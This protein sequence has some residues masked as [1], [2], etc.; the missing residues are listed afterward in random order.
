M[1]KLEIIIRSEKLDEMK[2]ILDEC[3]INGAIIS[4]IMGYGRQKGYKSAYKG[5]EYIINLLPKIK[6]EIIIKDNLVEKII[7][8]IEER[9][10]TDNIGDGKIFIYNVEDCVKI[11]T[12]ERGENAL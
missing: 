4:D 12:G 2:K 6:V 1:K 3:H 5:S 10:S 11:R 9:I 8:L 7:G